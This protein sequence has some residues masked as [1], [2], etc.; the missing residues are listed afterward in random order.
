MYLPDEF[1]KHAADCQRMAKVAR[2]PTAKATWRQ[3]SERWVQCAEWAKNEDR[4]A[5]NAVWMRQ[6]RMSGPTG[7]R[8]TAPD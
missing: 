5:S 1:L 3:M 2:D 6:H 4:L 8:F 7:S